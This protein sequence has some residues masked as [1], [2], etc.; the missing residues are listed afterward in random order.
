MDDSRVMAIFFTGCAIFTLIPVSRPDLAVNW[1]VK[2]FTWSLKLYGL[3]VNIRSTPR[4][5]AR[6]RAWNVFG[7]CVFIV[8]AIVGYAGIAQW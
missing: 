1:T 8:L 2:Y 6:C 5:L 7:L 4:A 3:E